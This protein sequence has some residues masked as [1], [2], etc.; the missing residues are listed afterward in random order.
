MVA[1]EPNYL[2]RKYRGDFDG[3]D[4]LMSV[5]NAESYLDL[6]EADVSVGFE[7]PRRD[8]ILRT[9]VRNAFDFHLNEIFATIVSEYTDWERASKHPINIRESLVRALSDGHTVAP[10]VKTLKYHAKRNRNTYFMVFGYEDES[11]KY[12]SRVRVLSILE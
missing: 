11:G 3:V 12:P 7:E 10:V 5:T 6:N 2:L 4:L 9:F 8:K 1:A